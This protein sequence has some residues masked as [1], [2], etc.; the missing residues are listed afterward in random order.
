MKNYVLFALALVG[1][2][3]IGGLLLGASSQDSLGNIRQF[4]VSCGET[5][6]A[7]P[8]AGSAAI[9]GHNAIKLYNSSETLVYVGNSAVTTATGWPIGDGAGAADTKFGGNIKNGQLYCIVASG[10]VTIRCISGL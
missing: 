1:A 5:A 8:A 9:G 6:T 7:I 10:T 4:T 3:A 2:L